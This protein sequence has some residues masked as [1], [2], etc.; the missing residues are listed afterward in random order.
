MFLSVFSFSIII[1]TS[2]RINQ[3]L[4]QN[5]RINNNPRA[6]EIQKQVSRILMLQVRYFC[7]YL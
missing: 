1:F 3:Q 5:V 7:I 2:Y 4:K 6:M